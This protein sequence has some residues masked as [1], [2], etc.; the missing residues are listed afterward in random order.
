MLLIPR[1]HGRESTFLWKAGCS[2]EARSTKLLLLHGETVL[3]MEW[4][5]VTELW[6]GGRVGRW[7]KWIKRGEDKEPRCESVRQKSK[8]VLSLCDKVERK[9][10]NGWNLLVQDLW[11]TRSLVGTI[12]M[13]VLWEVDTGPGVK[14][15]YES[16]FG[17]EGL[18]MIN[19]IRNP[20]RN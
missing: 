17:C 5:S 2:S 9:H 20:V 13:T 4:G 8:A 11:R 10:R 1:I 3:I 15:P 18:D 14:H 16:C 12:T 19:M 6:R 7:G